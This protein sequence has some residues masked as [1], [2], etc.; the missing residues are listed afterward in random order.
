MSS[1]VSRVAQQVLDRCLCKRTRAAARA[2]TR[3]YDDELRSTGLRPTQVELLVTVAAKSEL[4]ISAL[5]DELAMDRTT[6]TRN[7]RPLEKRGL[8]AI[9]PEGRHRVRLVR[10]TS[11]GEAALAG[12]VE[13]WQRAQESMERRLGEQGVANVRR[14][15]A[16]IA[17]AAQTAG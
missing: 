3:I 10:L 15:S 7:L 9:S 13:H 12:A 14:A 5:A 11:T 6:M 4:S 1:D 17:S 8:I 2:I 16:A